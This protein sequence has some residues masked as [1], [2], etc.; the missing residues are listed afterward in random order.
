[1]NKIEND[2]FVLSSK[3]GIVKLSREFLQDHMLPVYRDA[4]PIAHAIEFVLNESDTVD[5]SQSRP[6]L[7]SRY[8]KQ[9][10]GIVLL[11]HHSGSLFVLKPYLDGF[12][13]TYMSERHC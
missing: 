4:F 2:L 3:L 9:D 11:N 5:V 13:M 6:D 10:Q 12:E 1:M 8:A 7:K